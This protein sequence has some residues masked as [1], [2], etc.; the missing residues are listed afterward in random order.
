MQC[1]RLQY[2]S[3]TALSFKPYNGDR[4]KI[5]GVVYPI[6]SAGIAGL[7]PPTSVFKE[8]VAAQPLVANTTYYVYA[9]NNAGTITADFSTTG[10]ATSATAGNVGVEIKSGNDT[11]TL[12]G[13]IR[14]NASAQFQN[15]AANRLVISWFNRMNIGGLGAHTNGATTGSASY[16]ELT[17]LARMFFLTW[18]EE[19]VFGCVLGSCGASGAGG[20]VSINLGLDN[21][22]PVWNADLAGT[23]AAANSPISFGATALVTASE[24]FHYVTPLCRIPSGTATTTV[25][26][27]IMIRG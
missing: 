26:A 2:V 23:S 25:A 8:G 27:G 22:T 16:V 1:G 17:T 6:P 5:N 18:G 3:A 7:T 24:G 11:R 15:D 19:A 20:N 4:I 13:L 10:H 21:I 14:T 12:I 9:F